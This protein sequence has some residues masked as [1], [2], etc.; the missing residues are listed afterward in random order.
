MIGDS[1]IPTIK[2]GD[3][4]G[5]VPVTTYR[6]PGLYSIEKHGEPVLLRA[7]MRTPGTVS[8]WYDNPRYAGADMSLYA[9]SERLLGKVCAICQVIDRPLMTGEAAP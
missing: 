4:A 3:Y 2:P 9:F 7:E 6:G 8:V 1:M 5:I